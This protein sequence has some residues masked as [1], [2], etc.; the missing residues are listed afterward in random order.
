MMSM[1]SAIME[2][3]KEGERERVKKPLCLNNSWKFWVH[4][5]HE[6]DWSIDSYK[7]I[8]NLDTLEESIA[9]IENLSESL[10]SNCMLF[11]MR[12][13]VMPMWEDKNNIDGGS[14]S[15]KI[16][17]KNVYNIW[18][19][20][21]YALLGEVL[22]QTPDIQGKINGLSISPKKNFC[23]IKVWFASCDP[24]LQ[25]TQESI[26]VDDVATL[27]TLFKPFKVE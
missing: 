4:L 23:I 5:P 17:N 16:N 2:T 1:D 26:S 22:G 15:Y 18:K 12:K 11:M 25:N 6:T 21:L 20:L 14:V 19:K 13:D 9:L 7:S 24:D 8:C 3:C 27:T 10:V